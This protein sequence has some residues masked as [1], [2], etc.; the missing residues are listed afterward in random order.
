MLIREIQKALKSHDLYNPL[1]SI[2]FPNINDLLRYES[3][4]LD[5]LCY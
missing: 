5:T 2:S 4:W 1:R 3:L